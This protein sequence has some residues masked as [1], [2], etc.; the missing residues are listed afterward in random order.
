[1]SGMNFSAEELIRIIE[2]CSKSGVQLFKSGDLEV[3]FRN[4]HAPVIESVY[5]PEEVKQVAESQ[6]REAIEQ[7]EVGYKQEELAEMLIYDPAKLEELI[8]SGDLVDE[9]S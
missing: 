8:R 6:A 4:I 5:V 7:E 3:N 9:K 1:M 2:V